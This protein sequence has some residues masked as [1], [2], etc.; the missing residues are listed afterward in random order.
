MVNVSVQGEIS[1]PGYSE[2]GKI[3]SRGQVFVL[4]GTGGISYNVKSVILP[5]PLK[6]IILSR[7]SAPGIPTSAAAMLI[8]IFPVLA[9]K[10]QLSVEMQKERKGLLQERMVGLNM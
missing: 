3:D 8:I 5:M 10:Q 9:T 6:Q 7:A 1:P 4:P 2:V